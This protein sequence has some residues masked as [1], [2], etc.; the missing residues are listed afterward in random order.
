[1]RLTGNRFRKVDEKPYFSG[2]KNGPVQKFYLAACAAAQLEVL[3]LNDTTEERGFFPTYCIQTLE[4]MYFYCFQLAWTVF[5]SK[6]WCSW[7]T[8]CLSQ[9]AVDGGAMVAQAAHKCCR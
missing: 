8:Y 1:M 4:S 5:Y 7:D 3:L 2:I 9:E 6:D